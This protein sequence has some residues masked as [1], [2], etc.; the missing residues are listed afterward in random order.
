MEGFVG[1]KKGLHARWYV[2]SHHRAQWLFEGHRI[3][4]PHL[5]PFPVIDRPVMLE[6]LLDTP[7]L[8]RPRAPDGLPSGAGD[9]VGTLQPAARGA[10][11]TEA[12]AT[13]RGLLPP[14]VAG[15]PRKRGRRV[16]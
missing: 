1:I 15:D 16:R 10:Q 13:A 14:A 6:L 7:H 9:S 12:P 8:Q 11:E 3:I 5:G 4:E 2:P